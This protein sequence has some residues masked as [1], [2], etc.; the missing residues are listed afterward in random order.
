MYI[1]PGGDPSQD[2]GSRDYDK[3]WNHL[4]DCLPRYFDGETTIL[5]VADRHGLP[6]PAVR[7]Y[8]RKF[9]EK[10]LVTLDAA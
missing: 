4:M 5:Q 9:A 3:V 2:P 6:F 10:G 8:V 1:S 7:N